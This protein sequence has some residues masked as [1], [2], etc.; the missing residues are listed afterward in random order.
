MS[1][2]TGQLVLAL[3]V[4]NAEEFLP[5]TLESLNAQGPHLRWWLQDGASNDRTVEIARSFAREG[6]FVRSEKD[7]GQTDAIN[8]AF[9]EMGGDIIGF[10]NGDD[11]L[12]PGTAEKVITFFHEH[13]EIDLVYGQVEWIDREGKPS[14]IHS[15]RIGSLPEMLDIYNVWWCKRQWV[16]PE[17]FFRR[18][19]WGKVNGFDTRW[20]LA[21]DYDFWVRCIIAGARTAHIPEVLARFRIHSA[22]KSSA[23]EK[24]ADE[25]RAIVRQHL[26]AHA[27]IGLWKQL[28]L[29]AHLSYDIYQL[30]KNLPS[31]H[32]PLGFSR[33]LLSHPQWLLCQPVRKRIQAALARVLGLE[34]HRQT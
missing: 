11:L 26:D 18:S 12:P 27:P 7:G 9:R 1:T 21:F 8:R 33:A 24:V 14:G 22:Q 6:D 34:R 29:R 17:V 16:Q 20:N 4:F 10:I 31:G 32:A 19:L 15:G 28:T 2:P 3:P 25:I 30:G 13:P 23:T 5:A